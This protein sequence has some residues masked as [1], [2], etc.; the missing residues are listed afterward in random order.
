MNTLRKI[1]RVLNAVRVTAL[2]VILAA[3]ICMCTMNIVLRYL[4]KGSSALRPFPWVDELMRMGTIW[5]AFLAAGLGVKEGS[6]VSLESLTE[7]AFPPNVTRVLR[8]VA[9]LVVLVTLAALV[10]YGI[11]TTIR[12]SRSYLTNIRISNGWFYAAIPVGCGYLFYDYLLIF[13]FGSHPFSKKKAA[14]SAGKEG[15]VC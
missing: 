10:Y 13:L 8:K 4:I 7:R 11:L 5:I 14:G 9:Q 2:V 12:Q 1:D 6:H 15:S 3:T